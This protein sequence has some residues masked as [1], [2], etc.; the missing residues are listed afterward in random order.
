MTWRRC[1]ISLSLLETGH[2]PECIVR[3]WRY[4]GVRCELSDVLVAASLPLDVRG[5]AVRPGA[6]ADAWLRA[7][8]ECICAWSLKGGR[9]T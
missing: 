6:D 9:R 2:T 3:V 7:R 4:Q 8:G 5:R 1:G